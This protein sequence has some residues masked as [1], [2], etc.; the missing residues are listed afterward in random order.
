MLLVLPAEGKTLVDLEQNLAKVSD[1]TDVMEFPYFDKVRVFLPK[2]K[3][4]SSIE[5]LDPL[6]ALGL[7]DM[8]DERVANFSGMTVGPEKLFVSKVIQKAF[9]EVKEEGTE[10]A[11]ATV[12]MVGLLTSV[13]TLYPPKIV[14]FK[15]DRPFMFFIRD[16]TTNMILFSGHVIDPSK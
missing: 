3:I 10:A 11:A 7:K 4:E 13:P 6:M 15:C 8:F 12:S 9:V 2:F 1:I 5:L 14:T 16:H